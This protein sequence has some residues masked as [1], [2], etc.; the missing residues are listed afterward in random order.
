[1]TPRNRRYEQI[2]RRGGRRE[3]AAIDEMS[4]ANPVRTAL[5]IG[6]GHQLVRQMT[7]RVMSCPKVAAPVLITW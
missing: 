2:P 3:V 7:V 1:M 4:N 6:K 5:H